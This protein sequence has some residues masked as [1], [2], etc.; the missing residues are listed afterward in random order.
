MIVTRFAPS[1]TGDLHIGGARTA[2]FAWLYAKSSDGKC[3]LRLEDTDVQR[4]NEAHI[5]S[6]IASF[7]WLGLNF[8]GEVVYQSSRKERHLQ[9]VKDLVNSGHAYKCN[10][11][12]KR[13]TELRETQIKNGL[14]PKYDGHC[15]ELFNKLDKNCVVRF[16][17]PING[18]VEYN[19]LI[20]GKIK[21][22]NSELDDLIL[23][24]SDGSPTYNLSVVVDDVDM[25]I[26][27]VIRGDDH[28]N[29]T[30]RQIN[31]FKALKL[32]IPEYGHVPMIL[33]EDG[34][35]MSKRHGAVGVFEY[36]DLGISSSA[37]INYLVRLGWSF[38]DQE[39]FSKEELIEVFKSGKINSS[40]STFSMQ[41][42]KWFN[43]EYLNSCSADSLLSLLIEEDHNFSK[44]I[45]YSLKII[46]LLRDRCSIVKEFIDQS[47]YFF[48]EFKEY[49]KKSS[50]QFLTKEGIKFISTLRD[51]L[52]NLTEWNKKNI[53]SSIVKVMEIYGISMGKIGQPFRVAI[54]GSSQAPSI[55]HTAE[56]LGKEKVLNR[57][58]RAIKEFS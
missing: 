17:N 8:D 50:S 7:K 27:H 40:P 32:N 57:I 54:T 37:L 41:K 58:E 47:I 20:K 48:E 26:S 46:N 24:R 22:S 31:I 38:G 35:R 55:D 23:L 42:L 13:L 39:L 44:D 30:P 16:K 11:S 25:G 15:R 56:I 36:K 33:G 19:D 10:C 5:E 28:I 2:L 29:N 1:P 21:I 34:K 14:K 3:F 6:I 9:L 45:D 51:E 4:S 18:Y 53:H 12:K 43:K 52:S 49:D